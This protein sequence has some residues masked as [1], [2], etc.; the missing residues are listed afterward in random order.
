MQDIKVPSVGE[1]VT[2]AIIGEWLKGDGEYVKRNEP[3]VVLESDKAN[4]E[5]VAEAS[6]ALKRGAEEGD[7]VS[8]GAHH[9]FNRYVS[10]GSSRIICSG[11]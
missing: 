2:E 5:V 4:F 1:S 3:L 7:T 11:C 6:G 8:V 9:W 10:R